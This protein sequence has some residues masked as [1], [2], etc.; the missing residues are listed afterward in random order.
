MPGKKG[1]KPDGAGVL[2]GLRQTLR[3]LGIAVIFPC[4]FEKDVVDQ[5][6]PMPKHEFPH[7]RICGEIDQFVGIF[8]K[9]EKQA[10]PER[11]VYQELVVR[12][13][14]HVTD[15]GSFIGA[16][17]AFGKNEGPAGIGGKEHWPS[18]HG[19]RLL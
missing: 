6:F 8:P 3:R 11:T 10:S 19:R 1:L 4:A 16:V 12:R 17:L 9:A 14:E 15:T 13:A 18:A 5:R 7:R 2:R